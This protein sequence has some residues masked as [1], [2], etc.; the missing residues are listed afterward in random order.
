MHPSL[1]ND[2]NGDYQGADNKV[3]TDA[4]FDNHT[5]FS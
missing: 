2:F 3:Y 5:V 1:F 4:E